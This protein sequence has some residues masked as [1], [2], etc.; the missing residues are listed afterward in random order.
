MSAVVHVMVAILRDAAGRVLITQRPSGK[1]QAGRW[2][3]PGGKL[4]RDEPAEAGLRRELLEELGIVAGP[5]QRLIE[6]RHDYPD[7]T[8]RLDVREVLHFGG[9]PHGREGQALKWV[10]PDD[11]PAEDILEADQPVI[12]SLRLPDMCM[13]TPDPTGVSRADFLARLDVSLAAGVGLVQLRA[14]SLSRSEFT[15]LARDVLP[16]CRRHGARLLL[17]AMPDVLQD[18]DADGVHLNGRNLSRMRER[19]LAPTRWL[20]ASVHSK[21]ELHRAQAAGVDFVLVSPVLATTSHPDRKPLG[22]SGFSMLAREARVPVYALGGLAASDV[23]IARKH[24][25][26]GIAAIRG[27]WRE[28]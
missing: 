10:L 23:E 19:T 26:R 3:F 14:P 2:E 12:Q 4:E 1:P 18:V 6:I 27:L 17:N 8:V 16:V 28:V 24:G 25:G 13:I 15:A 9:S 22:W 21:G 7:F 5:M 20:S 11:L